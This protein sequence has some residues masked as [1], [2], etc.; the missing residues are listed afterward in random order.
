MSRAVFR[1]FQDFREALIR[2]HQQ[3][4]LS[5]SDLKGSGEDEARFRAQVIQD[6]IALDPESIVNFY[7]GQTAAEPI[8]SDY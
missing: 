4:W 6:I 3:R 1:Y 2:D 8:R 7:V 5:N